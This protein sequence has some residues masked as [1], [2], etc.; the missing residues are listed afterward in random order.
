MLLAAIHG[1]ESDVQAKRVNPRDA[2]QSAMDV[3]ERFRRLSRNGTDPNYGSAAWELGVLYQLLPGEDARGRAIAILA[4]VLNRY[5]ST[6]YG[7][8]SLRDLERGV[9]VRK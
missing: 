4:L 6:K 7:A 5:P 8:W 2:Y 1:I 9:G 3:E